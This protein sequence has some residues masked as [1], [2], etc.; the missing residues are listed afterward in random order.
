MY[1]LQKSNDL[2]EY[3]YAS[4]ALQDVYELQGVDAERYQKWIEFVKENSFIFSATKIENL[5][6]PEHWKKY[7]KNYEG[8]AIEFEIINEPV[9]WRLFY[10]AKVMYEQLGGVEALKEE[11]SKIQKDNP[12]NKYFIELNQMLS[13]HK[14]KSWVD[15]D[16]IRIYTQIPQVEAKLWNQNI[17]P[18][19]K[20]SKYDKLI[21]YFKLPLCDKDG[22]YITPLGDERPYQYFPKLR[23]SNIYFGADFDSG[24]LEFIDF[25]AN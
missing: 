23:I 8:V 11:W 24:E 5:L 16:E 25:R 21:K 10:F 13:F 20:F 7:G 14:S 6:N 2:T 4:D 9:D 19:A 15:E 17:F 12:N 3:Q 22:N 18:D 1:N